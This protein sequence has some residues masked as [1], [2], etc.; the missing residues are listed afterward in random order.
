MLRSDG[1]LVRLLVIENKEEESVVAGYDITELPQTS[2][3]LPTDF[4]DEVPLLDG[5]VIE[6]VTDPAGLLASVLAFVPVDAAIDEARRQLDQAGFV[7][8]KRY[9]VYDAGGISLAKFTSPSYLVDLSVS[10]DDTTGGTIV[11]YT[12]RPPQ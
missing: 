3:P 10:A 12:V 2:L 7:F 11:S 9:G 5:L 8:D 1:Y 6:S 4:P